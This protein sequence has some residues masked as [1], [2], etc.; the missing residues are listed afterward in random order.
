MAA[1]LLSS[2]TLVDQALAESVAAPYVL[3]TEVSV[4]EG[5]Q[6]ETSF[7][8]QVSM[9][10]WS[11]PVTVDVVAVPGSADAGDYAVATT[12]LTLTGGAAPVT[13]SGSVRGDLEYEGEESFQLQAVGTGQ[14]P[15]HVFSSGGRVV[16]R[17]DDQARAPRLSIQGASVPEGDQGTAR[18]DLQVTL[19]P[20][21]AQPVLVD[22]AISPSQG[23][24]AGTLTFSPGQTQQAVSVDVPGDTWWEADLPIVV[25]LHNP[26]RALVATERADLLVLN[27]DAPSRVAL[28]DGEIAEGNAGITPV[29]L[30]FT[31]DRPTPPQTK[32]WVITQA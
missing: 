18:V 27:D 14:F 2:S 24:A 21:A 31:Y 12:R 15:S 16:I 30:T 32:L 10:G 23:G 7:T 17:D 20:A 13:V 19:A 6:G 11:G 5:D 25:S 22:Y 1:L 4:E 28:V 3:I 8:A 9:Q 29:T 26:R